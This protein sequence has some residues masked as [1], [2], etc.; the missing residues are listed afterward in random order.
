VSRHAHGKLQLL[1]LLLLLPILSIIIL[2]MEKYIIK[3]MYTIVR[4]RK[5]CT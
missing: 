1:L 4:E 2:S 3:I 5:Y